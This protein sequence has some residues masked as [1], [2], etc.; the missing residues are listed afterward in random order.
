MYLYKTKTEEME[1]QR[2]KKASGVMA[3]ARCCALQI[4]EQQN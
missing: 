4:R 1:L 2:Q 3:T